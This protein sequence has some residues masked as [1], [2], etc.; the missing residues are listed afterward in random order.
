MK[1]CF[2][3]NPFAVVVFMDVDNHC[4]YDQKLIKSAYAMWNGKSEIFNFWL[5]EKK[6]SLN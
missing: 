4:A 3:K 2:I 6:L 5:T 1:N